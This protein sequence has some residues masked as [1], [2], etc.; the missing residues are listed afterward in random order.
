MRRFLCSTLLVYGHDVSIDP[1]DTLWLYIVPK[2]PISLHSL[3]QD[4]I[5][6]A[7]KLRLYGEGPLRNGCDWQKNAL[8]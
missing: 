6:A 4:G 2:S 3:T 7:E 8:V 5:I 1:I